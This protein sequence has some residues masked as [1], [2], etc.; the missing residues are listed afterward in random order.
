MYHTTPP[1]VPDQMRNQGQNRQKTKKN[2]TFHGPRLDRI[3]LFCYSP[4][5]RSQSLRQRVR[6][7]QETFGLRSPQTRR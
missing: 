6:P 1:T 7:L 2:S 3:F 5:L 4:P